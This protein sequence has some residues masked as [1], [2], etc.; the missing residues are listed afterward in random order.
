MTTKIVIQ[1]GWIVIAEY[2]Y[3]V[4][5]SK[6]DLVEFEGK[7][8]EVKKLFLEIATNTMIILL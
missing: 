4:T 2:D 8:L 1:R 6:G 3:L 7:E 5:M